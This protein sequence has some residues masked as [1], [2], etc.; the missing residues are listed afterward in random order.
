MAR[1]ELKELKVLREHFISALEEV[2][3]AFGVVEQELKACV[4]GNM[5][6][7]GPDYLHVLGT[8]ECA[9]AAT[10]AASKLFA[11]E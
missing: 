1:T 7:W 6:E 3:P 2:K 11:L 4:R 5:F 8:G 10:T 9:S